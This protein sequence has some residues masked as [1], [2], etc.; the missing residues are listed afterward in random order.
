V[1]VGLLGGGADAVHEL[2]PGRELRGPEGGGRASPVRCQ[3]VSPASAS[4]AADSFRWGSVIV[5]SWLRGS[6]RATPGRHHASQ[7]DGRPATAGKTPHCAGITLSRPG[8]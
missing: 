5:P 3:P 4:S 1:V 8:G 7:C 6:P 2:Q